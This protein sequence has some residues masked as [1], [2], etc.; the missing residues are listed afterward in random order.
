MRCQW[1]GPRSISSHGLRTTIDGVSFWGTPWVPNLQS[2][3]F[4]GSPAILESSFGFIPPGIDVMIS[5]SP[6]KGHLDNP[7]M[8]FGAS[9]VNDAIKRVKPKVFICGHIHEGYGVELGYKEH[10]D[11]Y[12]VSH[13]DIMY[14]PV[15]V[16]VVIDI[17]VEGS[18]QQ[19]KSED[20][21]AAD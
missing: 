8:L 13:C 21:D 20:S 3:A 18:W 12:N 1:P 5:H 9:Q 4:Y 16:P 2:W 7:Q 10:T 11:L 19:V 14:D 6:P 17:D 15:N